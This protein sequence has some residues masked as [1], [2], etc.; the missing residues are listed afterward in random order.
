MRRKS[1]AVI[2]EKKEKPK[3][4]ECPVNIK[5][6]KVMEVQDRAT[7]REVVKRLYEWLEDHPDAI[8]ACDTEVADIDVKKK[9]PVD[10]GEVRGGSGKGHVG[11]SKICNKGND[12][13]TT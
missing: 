2:A 3:R 6:V 9:G 5:D 12:V 7:A 1:A 11:G 13:I 8:F 4:P 10:N